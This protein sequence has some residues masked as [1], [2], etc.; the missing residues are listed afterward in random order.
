MVLTELLHLRTSVSVRHVV[1]GIV[2]LYQLQKLTKLNLNGCTRIT[3]AG[4][5]PVVRMA[6]GQISHLLG[7]APLAATSRRNMLCH[8]VCACAY[9]NSVCICVMHQ[10]T[11]AQAGC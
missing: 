6:S 7:R 3:D 9:A 5:N 11:V 10:H 2:P 1:A 4:L 8:L